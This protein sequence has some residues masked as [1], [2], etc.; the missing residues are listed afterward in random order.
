[1]ELDT[2]RV[3]DYAG[4]N[5]VHR[6][7]A[8][9]ADGKIV[10]LPEKSDGLQLKSEGSSTFDKVDEVGFE[11]S[12]LLI[13][14][15]ASQREYYE[16]LLNERSAP[17][18]RRGSTLPEMK[19]SASADLDKK[20]D[21]LSK[22]V[23]QLSTEVI[24]S[25]KNKIKSKDEKIKALA[26]ELNGSNMLNNGLSSKIEFLSKENEEVKSSNVDLQ[27]QV[28]DLMFFLESREKFKDQPQDVKDGTILVQKPSS[29]RPRKSKRK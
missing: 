25:L 4:D 16:M 12:Q 26:D 14:Q 8:N 10:E 5:Y 20:V 29:S 15:L 23:A 24:P 1:M 9:E 3:W 27:E 7:V 17:K 21:E 28:K 2:S 13:S 11:Y 19:V 18:S 22:Q 6:L